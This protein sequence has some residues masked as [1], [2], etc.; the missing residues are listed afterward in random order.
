VGLGDWL[1]AS[2]IA[3]GPASRGKRAAFGDGIRLLWD[4]N[5]E[6]IFRNNPNVVRPGEPLNSSDVEFVHYYKGKRWYNRPVQGRWEWNYDFQVQPGELYFTDG[7]RATVNRLS[8][9]RS[10]IVVEPNTNKLLHPNASY[11]I[12]K[13]WPHDK[14][15]EL[16]E[17]LISDGHCLVQFVHSNGYRLPGARLIQTPSFRSA[18]AILERAALYIGVEGGL[19]HS[20]AATG[21]P[22]VVL[23]GGW[24]PPSVLGYDTHINLTGGATTFCGLLRPCEHCRAAMDAISVDEVYQAAKSLLR[25]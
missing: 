25:R 13:Q 8:L 5:A 18:A 17:R 21:I 11:I 10:Y 22:A 16:A 4:S 15:G 23:F 14:Y 24:L 9:P 2:A 3:R 12:N 20:A 1:I 7:E 6:P 19:H